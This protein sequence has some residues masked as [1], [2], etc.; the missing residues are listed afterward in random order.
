[1]TRDN[2]TGILH[3]NGRVTGGLSP[4]ER[5]TG[6]LSVG[7][8]VSSY[9][10]LEDLPTVNGYEFIG[11]MTSESLGIWQPKDF[12]TTEQNTG[13]K[14]VDGKDIYM[15]S[16]NVAIGS[17]NTFVIDN[18]VSYD[19]LISITGNV[20]Y[21]GYSDFVPYCDTSDFCIIRINPSNELECAITNFFK[22]KGTIIA[23]IFYT[24]N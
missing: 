3:T 19:S 22:N 21:L 18:T 17:S 24:K 16:F 12:S 1:M 10:E 4:R 9:N 20:K 15:R 6:N 14:W 23:N 13:L 7:G 8:G 5:L 2:I 11:D